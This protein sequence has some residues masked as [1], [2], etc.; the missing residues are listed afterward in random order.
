MIKK[1]L[2]TIA[3]TIIA[4]LVSEE[5]KITKVVKNIRKFISGIRDEKKNSS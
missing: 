5:P 1:V 3:A 2:W 4:D